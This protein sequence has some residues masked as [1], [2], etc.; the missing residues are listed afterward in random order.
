MS[1]QLL[2]TTIQAPGFMGLNLQD[3]SVNLENG[4]ATVAT[5][6]IIDKFGRIGARKGWSPAHSSLAALTGY[7]VKCIGELIDNA[8]NSYIIATGHNKLFKLVGTTLSELTYGGGGTAPTITADNWQMAPLN[9]CIFLYQAGHDPLVF[10]PATS[11]TTYKRISEKTGYLGTVQSNNCVISAYGRTWSAN[12]ATNKSIIQFSDL[13]AGHV[14][15]TGTSGTLDVSQVWPAGAD[16]IIALAA[17]NNFLIIFGRRQIL[18]YANA[19]DPNNLTLSDAI[20]GIGCFARDSVAKTGSDIVFLSDTGV[21]SLMRTIQEKS[22]PMRELSLNVKDDLLD[23]LQSETATNIKSVYSDK[24]AF[25]LLSLPASN[26]VYCFDMRTQLPNGSARTTTWNNITPTAFF[27]T[28][29]KDLLLGKESYIGKYTGSLDNTDTYRLK[30]YTNYFDFGSPTALKILKKVNMTF[31]GGNGADIIVKYGFDFSPSYVS[32]VIQLGD[33][34]VSEYGI[35]QYNI[36]QYTA[37]VVYD[38]KKIHASGSGNVIQLGLET[39]I[40]DFEISLQK[41]DCYIKAGRTR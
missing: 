23:D 18:I 13:L 39:D 31:V 9:G 33:V 3:S 14:L 30:Y 34:S 36:G 6:C 38:N 32:R 20:T 37:G 12:N 22:A 28:R 11:A 7:N 41:L 35:A 26:T 40:N 8:G 17:H 19:T 24:D 10:D 29:N 1:E 25:Y 5:N 16:E 4:Y 15:N 27:Y 21:R 2:T